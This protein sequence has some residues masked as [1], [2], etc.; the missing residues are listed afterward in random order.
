MDLSHKMKQNWCWTY[1]LFYILLIRGC[2]RTQ[3]TPAYG[4]KQWRFSDTML[5]FLK[6]SY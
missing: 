2:Q 6:V 1:F 4:P 5:Y 3:R